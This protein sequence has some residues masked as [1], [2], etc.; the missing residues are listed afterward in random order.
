MTSSEE[1]WGWLQYADDT[2]RSAQDCLRIG[3]Y[4]PAVSLAYFAA[5]YAAKGVIAFSRGRDPRTQKG[6]LIRFRDLAVQESD[7][8][9]QT[10][11]LISQLAEE[12]NR[13]D[14]DFTYRD[15]WIAENLLGPDRESQ[16]LEYKST[17]R[18]DIKQQQKSKLIETAAT[19][20]IAG[21]AN[22]WYGGTFLIGVADDGSVHGLEDDY[23]T[24]SKRS[25]F[26]DHDL[27]G[28]HLR[29]LILNRLG[30][31]ALSLTTWVFHKINGNDLARINVNPSAHPIYDTKGKTETFWHRTPVSTL[32]I[33]DEKQ[34][35]QIIAT[36]W[37]Q[38]I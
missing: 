38:H 20:T 36:R 33:T 11:N 8:P 30:S 17:L 3:H 23:N 12:R 1:A 29:N 35:A 5:F 22:S 13:T 2:L 32:A 10:A 28:Q 31:Y 26:G 16:Y 27:W 9:E 6:V 18:W 14:Y 4:G 37:Q 24:F 21:F 7:F 19:K 25:Q 34:R 15:K